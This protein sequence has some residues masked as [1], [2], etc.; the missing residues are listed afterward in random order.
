[1]TCLVALFIL[2]YQVLS[3]P[4]AWIGSYRHPVIFKGDTFYLSEPLFSFWTALNFAVLPLW[5]AGFSLILANSNFEYRIKR[6]LWDAEL[7]DL[8]RTN[9]RT[10]GPD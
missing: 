8:E 4:K 7:S 6:R 5:A 9:A 3:S 2:Q 10:T 1:M